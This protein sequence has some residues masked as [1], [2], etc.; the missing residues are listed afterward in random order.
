MFCF[1]NSS[2]E[3]R[4]LCADQGGPPD[5]YTEITHAQWMLANGSTQAEVD[6]YERASV[7]AQI[8]ALERQHIAPRWQREFSLAVMQSMATPEQ[9]AAN[10]GYKAVKALD[11]QIAALRAQLEAL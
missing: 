1:Q 6:A 8:D 2:G 4:V 10:Y 9:L 5:G 7:Q 11:D 3:F